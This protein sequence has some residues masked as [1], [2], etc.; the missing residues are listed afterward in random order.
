[1]KTTAMNA[2]AGRIMRYEPRARDA[3]SLRPRR[4]RSATASLAKRCRSARCRR[5]E[6]LPV[7]ELSLLRR[8]PLRRRPLARVRRVLA[9]S[10]PAEDQLLRGDVALEVD[11]RREEVLEPDLRARRVELVELLVER[12]LDLGGGEPVVRRWNTR[13]AVP[14]VEVRL[15]VQR[16]QEV[17]SLLLVRRPRRHEVGRRLGGVV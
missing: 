7:L 3:R 9:A 2:A 13:Q 4:L 1:M 15:R 11:L 10:A 14:V 16:H 8:P 12:G 5:L 6:L 17:G